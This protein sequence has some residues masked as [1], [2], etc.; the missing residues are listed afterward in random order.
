MKCVVYIALVY[1]QMHRWRG[2]TLESERNSVLLESLEFDSDS[3]PF[4]GSTIQFQ[5][6]WF[7]LVAWLQG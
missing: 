6:Q 5:F 2:V 4:S 3:I 7:W 1:I